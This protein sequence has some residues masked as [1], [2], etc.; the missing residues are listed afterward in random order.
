MLRSVVCLCRTALIIN[1]T[2]LRTQAMKVERWRLSTM[3]SPVCGLMVSKTVWPVLKLSMERKLQPPEWFCFL[4]KNSYSYY[5]IIMSQKCCT[6][7]FLS[8]LKVG[9]IYVSRL[10]RAPVCV[11]A[12][13]IQALERLGSHCTSDPVRPTCAGHAVAQERVLYCPSP[14]P[15]PCPSPCPWPHTS[16]SQSHSQSYSKSQSQPQPYTQP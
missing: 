2:C 12:G 10:Q 13:R 3:M 6:L 1:S 15:C 16:Q 7:L 5:V 9:G 8:P 4:K 11:W 14:C